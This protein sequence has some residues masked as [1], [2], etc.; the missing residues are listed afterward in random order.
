MVRRRPVG[1]LP[2]FY[3]WFCRDVYRGYGWSFGLF[4]APWPR[5]EHF[6]GDM[7]RALL[8]IDGFVCFE[9][10]TGCIY[11]WCADPSERPIGVTP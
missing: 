3:A 11:T 7:V 9:R 8:F 5:E 6:E 1:R 10:L 4:F 2:F